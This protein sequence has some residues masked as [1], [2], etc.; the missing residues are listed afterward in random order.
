[1]S[2]PQRGS[3][4]QQYGEDVSGQQHTGTGNIR[5]KQ[6]LQKKRFLPYNVLINHGGSAA[7]MR[8]LNPG[9]AAPPV[10]HTYYEND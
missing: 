2:L 7:R 5:G 8:T 6:L 3:V 1:V 4:A 9:G 10:K